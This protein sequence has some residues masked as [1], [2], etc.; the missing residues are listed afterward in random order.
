MTSDSWNLLRRVSD[1]QISSSGTGKCRISRPQ[2]VS[3][4]YEY[5]PRI[6]KGRRDGDG[7]G[8][9]VAG[10]VSEVVVMVVYTINEPQLSPWPF[11][12][13]NCCRN[14]WKRK[15]RGTAPFNPSCMGCKTADS[16]A[17]INTISEQITEFCDLLW[18][19]VWMESKYYTFPSNNCT[20]QNSSFPLLPLCDFPHRTCEDVKRGYEGTFLWGKLP[21]HFLFKHTGVHKVECPPSDLGMFF[22]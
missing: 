1:C 21:L 11:H 15:W 8:W 22:F 17:G 20:D 14:C 2:W 9:C 16:A 6:R 7:K 10:G 19:W 18:N 4:A 3:Q 12:N 5:W 13:I